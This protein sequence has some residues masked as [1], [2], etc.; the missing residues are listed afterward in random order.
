M[1]K[2]SPFLSAA[3]SARLDSRMVDIAADDWAPSRKAATTP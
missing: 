2:H 3:E 1:A